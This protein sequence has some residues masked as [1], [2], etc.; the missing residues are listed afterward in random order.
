V[1]PITTT[2]WEV[3]PVPF[4]VNLAFRLPKGAALGE[5]EARAG[6][7]FTIVTEADA[8]WEGSVALAAVTVTVLDDGRVFGAVY[9]PVLLIVPK[10]ELPPSVAFTDHE[11]PAL[12]PL[13]VAENWICP[14]SATWAV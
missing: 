13:N 9:S 7:G 8:D 2:D 12:L 11:I 3:N 10:V 1:P 14:K 6:G 5:I 4:T